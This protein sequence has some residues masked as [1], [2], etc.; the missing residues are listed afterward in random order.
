MIETKDLWQSAYLL[1]EGGE[2]C[3]VKIRQCPNGKKEVV[4]HLSGDGMEDMTRRF[5]DGEATCNVKKLK[6]HVSHLKQVIFGGNS[7]V[8][9]L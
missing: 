1:A 8:R 9:E 7:V 3:G 5:K 6:A 2:L 4:F